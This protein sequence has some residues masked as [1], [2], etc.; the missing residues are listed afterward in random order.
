MIQLSNKI[1]SNGDYF[2]SGW[3]CINKP[4][5]MSSFDVVKKLR[6]ILSIKKLG[7]AGTLDPLATGILP[8]AFGNATKTI[9]YLVSSKKKYRFSIL[10]GVKTMSHDLEGKIIEK[11]DFIPTKEDILAVIS[12]FNG[13]IYQRPP[14]YSAVKV[15]GQRAY[16]LAREGIDFCIKEKKVRLHDLMLLDHK[17]DKT[18]FMASVG[19]GF[20]IRSLARDMCDKI[21]ALGVICS[22]E[23]F[24]LGHFSLEDAFS[25]ETIEKLVHSAPA[26][27]VGGNLLIPLSKVL[28]DIP[29][30]LISDKEVERFQHGQS[31]CNSDL[32]KNSKLG[33]EV[34]L[35]KNKRPI[36]LAIVCENSFKPKKVFSEEIFN[37]RSN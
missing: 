13:E 24:E 30:L 26:G 2:S 12:K 7:H 34:L 4:A 14:K 28:D 10:W 20:Y 35:L 18:E 16:K 5:N 8:I 21:G 23:R 32:L 3:I 19:K 22:L 11:S 29:A 37:L 33:S 17:T 25:L 1:K 36:G 31:F 6:R 15:D 27:M 9:P